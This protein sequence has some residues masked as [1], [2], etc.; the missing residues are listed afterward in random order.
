MSAAVTLREITR[1]NLRAVLRLAP[2]PGQQASVASNAVSIAQ[3]HFHPE[4]WCRA[5]VAGDDVA[6][7]VMVE[8]TGLAVPPAAQPAIALW[9]FMIDAP[10]QGQGI[11]R[12]AIARVVEHVQRRYPG[13][14]TLRTSVVPGPH[15]AKGFYE[16]LGFVATGEWDG[17]EEVLALALP[18]FDPAQRLLQ[19][20]D[21]I[22]RALAA[23]PDALALIGLGSV[24][25]ETARLDA[26]SDLDF[27]VVVAP[28][29]KAAYVDRL[30]WLAAAQPL[31]W[32]YRNAVDGHRAL[33]DDG[34]FCEFAVFEPA[35]LAA[36]PFAPGRV[37]WQRAGAPGGLERP[38]RAL[39]DPALPD[40]GWLVGEALSNLVV[41]LSRLARG[42]VLAATRLIQGHAVDRW[43]Q[44][45]EALWPGAGTR[46]PFA[47]ERRFEQRHPPQVATLAACVP[48]Y[49]GNVEAARALLAALRAHAD[50]PPAVAAHVEALCAAAEGR[51]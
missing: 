36:I 6:G 3:A 28:G 8:D 7:F 35:E 38:R 22:G 34:V 1:E 39:P 26:W 21:A 43:L 4:A 42:E 27:F 45:T 17:G 2:K 49:R 18:A 40:R 23:R 47:L 14:R 15:S 5:V 16:R 50:V 29:A 20:L 11:G 12:A 37:V 24:G 10:R 30:G 32:H 46:D 25:V 9:R 19:R 44:L 41:G 13:Q 48:G 51:G 31:A 33:M